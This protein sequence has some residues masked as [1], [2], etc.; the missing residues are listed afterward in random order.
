[1]KNIITASRGD[2]VGPVTNSRMTTSTWCLL[3]LVAITG[4]GLFMRLNGLGA[5]GVYHDEKYMVLAVQGVL[6]TGLPYLPSGMF[7]PRAMT[8]VYLMTGS[9]LA[10]GESE[11]AFRL[12]SVIAGTICIPLAYY[13]GR[14]H[15]GPV[16]SLAFAATIAFFPSFIEVSQIAR[17]YVFLVLTVLLFL[18]ALSHWERTSSWWAL[19]SMTAVAVIG[20][21]F[22]VLAVFVLPLMFIPLITSSSKK[23]LVQTG[24]AVSVTALAYKAIEKFADY[25][26]SGTLAS[27]TEDSE[28]Y[29]PPIEIAGFQ[30]LPTELLVGTLILALVG[31][32]L[33]AWFVLRSPARTSR[34]PVHSSEEPLLWL[35]WAGFV[36]AL[37]AAVFVS[38][39]VAALAFCAGLVS[40]LRV[41]GPIRGAMLVLFTI[42]L[43]FFGQAA[44]LLLDQGFP[45][46]NEF[47]KFF[48]AFPAPTPEIRFMQFFPVAVILFLLMTTSDLYRFT[49]G[50]PLPLYVILFS[51][52][53]VAPMLVMGAVEWGVAPRYVLGLVPVFLFCFFLALEGFTRRLG[54]MLNQRS[55]V[56]GAAP[57]ILGVIAIAV[58][59]Q[60]SELHAA[61]DRSYG[62]YPDHIGAA[63]FMREADLGPSDVVVVMEAPIQTYYLGKV[64]Y[65]LRSLNSVAWQAR[66]VQDEVL[67]IF[68]GT[69]VLYDSKRFRSVISN[70]E[71]GSVY[72]ISSGEIY[73]SNAYDHNL[74]EGILGLFESYDPELVFT[75]RDKKTLIW[76]FEPS[77]HSVH[78]LDTAESQQ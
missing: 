75:G 16:L 32:A 42:A 45:G 72:V 54:V 22:Q 13:L 60:P 33:L 70:K 20:I 43:I 19:F 68:T 11:W 4:I 38:Y 73:G 28:R 8:Q 51:F 5:V 7:Y 66:Q 3:F 63:Q 34:R 29:P 24:V 2:W 37:I 46:V 61:L 58:H 52:G 71:Y 67:D 39:L 59:I 30:Q 65:L 64:D 77:N 21:E 12:P 25:H 78:S 49:K 31:I 57:A 74:G 53:V 9:V 47:I 27:V 62:E 36:I 15:I 10:F 23:R 6:E 48:I 56:N 35:G 26:Y 1:M 44:A 76:R 69:P 55:L 50:E 17:M 40:Y 14:L 41:N 18:I